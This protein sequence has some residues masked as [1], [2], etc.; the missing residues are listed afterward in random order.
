MRYAYSLAACVSGVAGR[1]SYDGPPCLLSVTSVCSRREEVTPS[2]KH[3][4]SR[5]SALPRLH[6]GS[7]DPL[8]MGSPSLY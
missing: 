7:V 8:P 5:M 4:E 2:P 3:D 6:D 1:N